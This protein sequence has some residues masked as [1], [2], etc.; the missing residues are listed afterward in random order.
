MPT[1]Q[2]VEAPKKKK[3]AVRK[4]RYLVREEIED[5]MNARIGEY[6]IQ[7]LKNFDDVKTNQAA[8]AATLRE[9]NV[10]LLEIKDRIIAVDGNGTGKIGLLQTLTS[11]VDTLTENVDT[12]LLRSTTWN[13][14][15]VYALLGGVLALFVAFTAPVFAVWLSHKL[16]W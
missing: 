13:K 6:H 1:K 2:T 11:N 4:R 12:L 10:A 5:L 8:T 14:K 3:R 9:Q 7:N 15:K 16:H